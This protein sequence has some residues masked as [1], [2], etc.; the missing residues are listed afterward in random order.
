MSIFHRLFRVSILFLPALCA[1]AEQAAWECKYE[2]FE[3]NGSQKRFVNQVTQ[4]VESGTEQSGVIG[5]L[6]VEKN[7]LRNSTLVA[8]KGHIAAPAAAPTP[9]AQASASPA[10]EVTLYRNVFEL[11]RP[12]AKTVYC[13]LAFQGKEDGLA[14]CIDEDN[15][16]ELKGKCQAL[17]REEFNE[18]AGPKGVNQ[19]KL[20]R[21]WGM[22]LETVDTDGLSE[23]KALE[24]QAAIA[25]KMGSKNYVLSPF[26]DLRYANVKLKIRDH[27]LY[28]TADTEIFSPLNGTREVIGS[29]WC[30]SCAG[31]VERALS[32]LPDRPE[33]PL[34]LEP[35]H[36]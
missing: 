5:T 16:F 3:L 22:Y 20:L 31:A 1:H 28:C 32:N 7:E 26:N 27:G 9:N 12:N 18:K 19:E 25:S 21:N 6:F 30:F 13:K 11:G 24:I 35:P 4:I 17:S 29:Y 8:L 33:R 14:Q 2:L 10:G 34:E 23:K 15:V 36:R